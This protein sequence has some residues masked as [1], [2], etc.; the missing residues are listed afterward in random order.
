M[1]CNKQQ[2]PHSSS[3]P[4]AP[5]GLRSSARA[6]T[7]GGGDA[8]ADAADEWASIE[9]TRARRSRSA[10]S[11]SVSR[12]SS[13]TKSC[14]K[15]VQFPESRYS[16]EQIIN[17]SYTTDQLRGVQSGLADGMLKLQSELGTSTDAIDANIGT[18]EQTLALL[19][20]KPAARPRSVLD[21]AVDNGDNVTSTARDLCLQSSPEPLRAGQA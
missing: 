2:H 12:S 7:A 4:T 3:S 13:V 17:T 20:F 16:M 9:G 5:Q 14:K 19:G 1:T 8:N 11:G 6:P 21:S 10:R 15:Q 18:S